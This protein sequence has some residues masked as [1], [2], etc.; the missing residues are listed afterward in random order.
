LITAYTYLH[1]AHS[2]TQI[3]PVPTMALVGG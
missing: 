1:L 2:Y 3:M